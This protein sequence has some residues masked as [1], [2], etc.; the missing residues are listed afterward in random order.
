MKKFVIQNLTTRSFWNK[1][2]GFSVGLV[3]DIMTFNTRESAES[4]AEWIAERSHQQNKDNQLWNY[5]F[6]LTILEVYV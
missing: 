5:G 2:D 1:V 3:P 4:T 6:V